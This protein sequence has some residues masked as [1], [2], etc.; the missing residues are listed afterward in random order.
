MKANVAALRAQEA[1][2]L[3]THGGDKQY[4]QIIDALDA[5]AQDDYQ[6]R[7]LK[8]ARAGL[9]HAKDWIH[10]DNERLRWYAVQS[11]TAINDPEVEQILTQ[12][13]GDANPNT[14]KAASWA[15]DSWHAMRYPR[16]GEQV[17]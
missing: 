5:M 7:I 16:R 15:L 11:F 2:V 8:N 6:R 1:A 13:K 4:L 17:K 14:A 12:M 9:D 10:S 3:Q